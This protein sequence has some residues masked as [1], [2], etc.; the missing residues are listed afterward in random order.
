MSNHMWVVR[1][2]QESIFVQE[3]IE[4]TMVAIGWAKLGDLTNV[5]GREAVAELM[6]R[7][8]SEYTKFQSAVNTGQ[9]YR[10]R[11]E[12]VE[13]STVITSDTAA[14]IY[15]IGTVTSDYKFC[16]DLHEELRH[17]RQVRWTNQI[18]R[19]DLT[20]ST[21][22]SLG[23]IAT[24]FCISDSASQEIESRIL[25]ISP[26]VSNKVEVESDVPNDEIEIRK[27]TEQ[28]ALEFLQDRLAALDWEEMQELVAGLLRAM[29]YKTRVSPPGADRGR[30]IIASPDGFGFQAPRIVVEVK[31][32][33]GAMGAGEIRAFAGGLRH[34]NS[35]LYV[36]TG[37]FSREARY[38]ADRANHHVALMDASDL[39]K[40]IVEHYDKMDT[41][42]R[43]L[44][45]LKKIYWPA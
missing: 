33:K 45:P 21:K 24:I 9:V 13:G 2:G 5:H 32:R 1:A 42:T 35:G 34:D 40:A 3:F 10:F 36:S 4:K 25:G 29:G 17:T 15:H 28:R 18:R 20:V 39:G 12:L 6:K 37:G 11:D 23:A 27:D 31:H 38:E 43:T 41:E 8:Y 30:D 16:P 22:N 14:R 19:D 7:E 44:L 26:T